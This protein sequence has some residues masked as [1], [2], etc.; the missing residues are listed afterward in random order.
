MAFMTPHRI[1][2]LV[3]IV[4]VALVLTISFGEESKL[5]QELQNAGHALLFG[6]AAI[7]LLRDLKADGREYL[8][9]F[10]L[11]L[12]LGIATE[13]MQ[14]FGGRDA[15]LLDVIRDG[16]GAA[17]FLGM[18]WTLQ[19]PTPFLRLLMLRLA[20]AGILLGVFSPP[21]LTGAAMIHRWRT[22]PL[23]HEFD[24]AISARFCSAR[25]ARINLVAAPWNG[26]ERA[27]QVTFEPA[28]YS[29]FTI[30]GP[31]PSWGSRGDLSFA[32]YSGQAQTIALNLRIH[33]VRHN[34]EHFD[35]FNQQ[36]PIKPGMNAVR[37][38]LD[39]I[40]KA[41]RGRRMDPAGIKAI[42]L[43][44]TNPDRDFDLYFGRFLISG[45]SP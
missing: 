36:L 5:W 31:W 8:R 15:E 34:N 32:V 35:R 7:L 6:A 22:F 10:S 24:T 12:G 2:S 38:P 45:Q 27:A 40:E 21:M 3:T 11:T 18:A 16:L 30:D 42:G 33:D 41:P 17:A 37:I 20:G 4:L 23:I 28:Q 25:Q 19:H 44:V 39:A 13:L 1:R 43:F 14:W 29:G 26:N 9:A